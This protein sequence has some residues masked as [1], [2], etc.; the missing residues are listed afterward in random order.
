MGQN[1]GYLVKTQS[2]KQGRTYHNK[3]LING[4]VPV[5]LV[6]CHICGGEGEHTSDCGATIG[7][8]SMQS[9]KPILCKPETLKII[10][11]VD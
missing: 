3:G 1:S 4:K 10:G 8:F 11:F 6:M 2:G 7:G 5:Y 9:D